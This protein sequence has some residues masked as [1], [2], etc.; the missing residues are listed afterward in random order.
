MLFIGIIVL[1]NN[2][3]T[4]E[5]QRS[6]RKNVLLALDWYH[7]KLHR[8]IADFGA[9]RGWHLEAGV[10]LG[11]EALP[12]QWRGDGAI[13]GGEYREQFKALYPSK[14]D[15][16][17]L[18]GHNE[19]YA[20]ADHCVSDDHEAIVE[21]A[22]DYL[23]GKGYKKF[24][25]YSPSLN[26]VGVRVK[27]F[28]KVLEG[29]GESSHFMVAESENWQDRHE[30]L[31][32][33]LAELPIGTAI[34]CQNDEFATEVI[35]ACI[36]A[37]IKVPGELAVLGVR[38]DP[39][40]CESLGIGLSSVDNNLYE[41]GRRAAELLEMVMKGEAGKPKHHKVAPRGVKERS[42]TAICAGEAMDPELSE[43]MMVIRNRFIDPN[44]DCSDLATRCF[45]SLRKLYTIFDRAHFRKPAEE[46]RWQRVAKVG[47]LLRNT[48]EPIKYLS[49]ACG[50]ANLRSLYAAFKA[51]EGKSPA[52]YRKHHQ[53]RLS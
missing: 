50:F 18:L 24:A 10:A 15:R 35:E 40:I 6:E 52:D 45:V 32:D 29:R 9:E 5:A 36:D 48:S 1:I 14:S 23:L 28:A 41:V 3:M 31:M 26:S 30:W 11:G 53:D 16:L 13:V 25:S 19:K 21:Q 33:R 22:V 39:L 4:T 38:N 49:E 7:P 42:S 27:H 20:E 43:A 46:I 8:G 44:F 34:F 47:E 37:T 2:C 51:I 17:V 12:L